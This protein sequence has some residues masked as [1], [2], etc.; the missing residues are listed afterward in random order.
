MAGGCS[1]RF[2]LMVNKAGQT[3]LASYFA[4]VHAEERRQVEAELV[5]K[6]LARSEKQSNYFEYK[7]HTVVFR[8]YASLFFIAGAHPNENEMAVLEFIHSCVEALDRYFG[9]V[10]ELDIMFHLDRAHFVL[11]EMAMSGELVDANKVN[12]L[13]PVQLLDQAVAT[14]H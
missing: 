13:T 2:M 3:R 5:R 12:A 14:R 9:S 8:R 11:E 6:C 7:N 4:P 10:C 1:V